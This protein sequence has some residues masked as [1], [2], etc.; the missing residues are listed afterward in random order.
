M[1]VLLAELWST[2]AAFY[3]YNALYLLLVGITLVIS[4]YIDKQ[5]RVATSR[6]K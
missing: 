3:S 2:L 5:K 1:S 6:I 4:H